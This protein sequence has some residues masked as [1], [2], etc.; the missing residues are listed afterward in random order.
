ME[1]T[2]PPSL[3][4]RGSLLRN[5]LFVGFYHYHTAALKQLIMILC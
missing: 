3:G 1:I 2:S 5:R 4:R